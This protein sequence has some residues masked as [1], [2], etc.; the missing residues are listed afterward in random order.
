MRSMD[1]VAIDRVLQSAQ[2]SLFRWEAR[3]VYHD[4]SMPF[5]RQGEC[6]RVRV[7]RVWVVADP[8]TK[9]QYHELA[10]IGQFLAA[11][12]DVRLLPETLALDLSL[13]DHDFWII[14]QDTVVLLRYTAEHRLDS[15][16]L[17]SD[18]RVASYRAMRDLALDHA[19]PLFVERTTS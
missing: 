15:G 2:D 11:R 4:P 13:P 16:L 8:P 17:V 10:R 7:Q 19:A 12:E 3:G 5:P 1:G 18:D 14:D 6:G 9:A